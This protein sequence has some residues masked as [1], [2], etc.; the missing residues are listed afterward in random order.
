M[1][2]SGFNREHITNI[3][4]QIKNSTDADALRVLIKQHT[5]QISDITSSISSE[6]SS[7]SSKILP[8]MS[9]PSPTPGSI[10]KWISKLIAGTAGPQVKALASYSQ[11]LA[12][13]QSA[14]NSITDAIKTLREA[15][16]DK[17]E[18]LAI[19]DDTLDSVRDLQSNIETTLATS[20]VN[21]QSATDSLNSITGGSTSFDTSSVEA[22]TSTAES[23]LSQLTSE[24]DVIMSSVGPTLVTSPTLTGDPIVGNTL[25]INN[26][27]WSGTQ[28]ITHEYQ[29]YIDNTVA[30]T[31]SDTFT[32]TIDHVGSVIRGVCITQNIADYIENEFTTDTIRV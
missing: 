29:W 7:I 4:D 21:L 24:Q 22:F 1:K 31:I 25:T 12:T 18:L 8:I 32:V 23:S 27:E 13:A 19:I 15:V 5:K 30:N 20:L 2:I 10:V 28:P 26:G 9:P 16:Q 17:S 3:S 14:T 11:H 6:M